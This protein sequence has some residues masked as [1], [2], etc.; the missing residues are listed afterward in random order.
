[1]LHLLRSDGTE[2]PL[3]VLCL[4]DKIVQQAVV[5]VLEAIYEADFLVPVAAGVVGDVAMAAVLAGFRP[6]AC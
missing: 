6:G 3:S 2:R 1:M 5:F 4:E